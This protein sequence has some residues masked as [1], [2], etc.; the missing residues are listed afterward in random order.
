MK[1]HTYL[2]IPAKVL[3]KKWLRD[4]TAV[5]KIKVSSKDRFTFVPGQF[6]MVSVLGFGEVPI[7]IASAPSNDRVI[8][9]LV[10][11]LGLVTKKITNLEVGDSLGVSKPMG[12]GF[13]MAKIKD[14]D[15]VLIAGG[16]GIAPLR[17]LINHIK[18]TKL[19]KS[20]AI[21]NGAKCP[22]QI[23]FR[24]EYKDWDKF[25]KTYL[26]VDTCDD[27][28]EQSIGN[29]T[30]LLDVAKIKRGSLVIVCG[31]PPMYKPIIDRLAGKRVAEDDLWFSLERRMKCGIGK[32]Q[33]CTC[34]KLYT[35]LDGPIFSYDKI[36][37]N[38]EAFK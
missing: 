27:S 4:D 26:T 20:L 9:L 18:K 31:P 17:S 10:M 29:I 7:G 35:C 25:A 12:N 2:P 16:T 19:T 30:V 22:E 32:C 28:W 21:L 15:L 3:S 11:R 13:P 38:N 8:E 37:Y 34:G 36:K 33:H 14:K 23:L 5:L 24:D 1:T 6:V